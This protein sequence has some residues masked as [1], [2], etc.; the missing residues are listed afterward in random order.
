[1]SHTTDRSLIHASVGPDRADS[2]L[3]DDGRQAFIATSR[4]QIDS[5]PRTAASRPAYTVISQTWMPGTERVGSP[6]ALRPMSRL[7]PSQTGTDQRAVSASST[8]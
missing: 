6:L 1:V 7:V 4:F 3:D 8:V 2:I 5:T